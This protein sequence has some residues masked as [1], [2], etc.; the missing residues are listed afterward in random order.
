MIE[1]LKCILGIKKYR[2]N[3][4]TKGIIDFSIDYW[5]NSRTFSKCTGKWDKTKKSVTKTKQNKK[6]NPRENI[7]CIK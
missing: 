4:G 5:K 7:Q 3:T 6:T 1:K 2:I